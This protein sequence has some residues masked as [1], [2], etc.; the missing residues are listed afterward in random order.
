MLAP[1]DEPP[2]QF[3]QLLANPSFLVKIKSY[4]R[5]FAFMPTGASLT[6]NARIGKKLANAR[7][8]V[9]FFQQTLQK[10]NNSYITQQMHLLKYNS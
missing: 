9:Y 8:G 1:L 6:D 3:K 7:E 5:I 10:L 4:N 2:Q